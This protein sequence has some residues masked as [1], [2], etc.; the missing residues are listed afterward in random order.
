MFFGVKKNGYFL[1]SSFEQLVSKNDKYEVY[2]PRAWFH[3][4]F[5]CL[6]SLSAF[7]FI[8]IEI[9]HYFDPLLTSWHRH[10]HLEES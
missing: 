10:S 2:L 7:L 9:F 6:F 3:S 1:V 8:E 4:C 5:C